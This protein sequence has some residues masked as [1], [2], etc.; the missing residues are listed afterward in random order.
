MAGAQ[1]KHE[2]E[3]M[4]GHAASFGPVRAELTAKNL[5]CAALVAAALVVQSLPSAAQTPCPSPAYRNP[6][7]EIVSSQQVLL[8]TINL[9]E[10]FIPMPQPGD[11]NCS[12]RPSQLVRVFQGYQGN[13]TPPSPP[14]GQPPI[15]TQ[16]VPGPTLRARV[17]DIVQLSFINQVNQNNFDLNLDIDACTQVGQNGSTYPGQAKDVMPD[18]LHASSTANIHF[19][20]THTS[21]KSTADNVY[22]MV[23]PLPRDRLGNPTTPVTALTQSFQGFFDLCTTVLRQNPLN[24]FPVSWNDLP[25]PYVGAQQYLLNQYQANNPTQPIWDEDQKAMKQGVWPQ[26][27]IGAYPYCFALPEYKSQA[28]PAPPGSPRMGQSPG[29]HWYHAHKHGSTAINVGNGMVGAFIIEGA[30]DDAL[31]TYYGSY[32]VNGQPWNTRTQKVM[33]LNQL[34]T[35]PNR[36]TGVFGGPPDF[37]VNG[38]RQPQL[39]MAPGEVQLWRIV[40]GAARSAAYFQ[41][42][43][44]L[45]WR[46]LAQDGVQLYN[47]NYLQSENQPIYVAPGNRI[48]LLVQAPPAI[49]PPNQPLEVRIQNVMARGA[50]LP[51]PAEPH[52][53]TDPD[54]STPLLTVAVTGQPPQPQMMQLIPEA[55]QQP[56]FLADITDQELSPP[57]P[58]VSAKTLVF[59]SKKGGPTVPQAAQHTINGQQ[60]STVGD[61]AL[62]NVAL[63]VAE[64]WTISNSTAKPPGPGL[65]DHPF[66][67]HINPFQ[68]TEVFD[69]NENLTDAN[70]VIIGRFDTKSQKTEPISRYLL[71][72]DPPDPVYGSRQCVLDPNN[73]EQNPPAACPLP[74]AGSHLVWWDVFAI[75]SGRSAPTAT[76]PNNVIPGYFKMRSRF[77]DYP[78]LYVL[79][80]HIL[81]HEDRGMMFRVNVGNDPSVAVLQHH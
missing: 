26:Y 42:P 56:A 75:P 72:G 55:P 8:G 36:M 28:W 16:P 79:H 17:G 69:P 22:L 2:E 3:T 81:I 54:P 23:R 19:H 21:P 57:N 71:P 76:N 5:G 58:N 68:I 78:G 50:V 14:P 18:C 12:P 49:T 47:T 44:G 32:T 63:N 53:K 60:F 20:G 80:C 24:Q 37:V 25:A 41:A 61:N 31:N 40:N 33:V 7:T 29:T 70:G 6:T 13:V 48:D 35:V 59:N 73:P 74:K 45:R 46:Q 39:E 62:V 15:L 4:T 51:I 67:I 43:K 11:T 1:R 9:T 66:H 65:I 10:Q 38:L 77:V 30:Y 52:P 27:Y 64:Q 34:Q